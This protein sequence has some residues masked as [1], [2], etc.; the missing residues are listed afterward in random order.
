MILPGLIPLVFYKRRPSNLMIAL[1]LAS[2]VVLSGLLGYLQLAGS[3]RVWENVAI[4]V[5]GGVLLYVAIL[6]YLLYRYQP[7][8]AAAATSPPPR[9]TVEH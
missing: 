4:A 9:E 7:K 2:T 8:H 1:G 3:P 5:I 6:W